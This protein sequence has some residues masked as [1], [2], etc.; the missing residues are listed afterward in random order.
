MTLL[1]VEDWMN[2]PKYV[3]NADYGDYADYADYAKYADWA[4]PNHFSSLSHSLPQTE[5]NPPYF[6]WPF[7]RCFS[8][9]KWNI[10]YQWSQ[11]GKIDPKDY[12]R[13]ETYRGN[14]TKHV[15]HVSYRLV[16]K[17]QALCITS[18]NI[19][20]HGEWYYSA[21]CCS[22]TVILAIWNH[23]Q[24]LSTRA[25]HLCQQ[26]N[27]PNSSRKPTMST[28]TGNLQHNIT[29]CTQELQSSSTQWSAPRSQLFFTLQ[30]AASCQAKE[31]QLKSGTI[32][33]QRLCCRSEG[34]LPLCRG[35]DEITKIN[36]YVTRTSPLKTAVPSIRTSPTIDLE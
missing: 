28:L 17:K 27:I 6:K 2:W 5:G 14:G 32:L 33:P 11:I 30:K 4:S 34:C 8:F 3:Y 31:A 24:H 35:E 7:G 21:N 23:P 10:T 36:F 1:I 26:P 12:R 20:D 18:S 9:Q 15:L 22:L 25:C 13:K 29:A 19:V 16:K